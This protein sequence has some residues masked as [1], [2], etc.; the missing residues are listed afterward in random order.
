MSAPVA[1]RSN[2]P[3]LFGA[4]ALPVLEELFMQDYNNVSSVRDELFRIRTTDRDI[5]QS[6]ELNDLPGFDLIPEGSEYTYRRPSAGFNATLTVQ[7]YGGGFSISRELMEDA[8]FDVI[9]SM[10][11]KLG[12]SGRETQEITAMNIFNNGFTSQVNAQD[13]VPLF[14]AAHSINGQ[15]FSNIITGNPDLS[16]SALQAALAQFEQ[17]WINGTGF[18]NRIQPKVLVVS[19]QN[20]RYAEELVGSTLKADTAN[21]NLNSIRVVDGLRVVSSPY[22][23]DPDAWFLM[24]D[25]EDTGLTIIERQGLRVESSDEIGFHTDS[26][27]FKASYR[28]IVAVTRAAGILGSSG[29]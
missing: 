19:S 16:E 18:L 21:N 22:L 4:G 6:S 10:T 1:L 26:M 13:G 8:R 15:T 25:P 14:S 17:A 3:A 12:R 2:Y 28:E 24:G 27:F 5:W 29:T 20:R 23:T 9:S 11:R 7:K